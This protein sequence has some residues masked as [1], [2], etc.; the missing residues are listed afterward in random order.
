MTSERGIVQ[1]MCVGGVRRQC[2]GAAVPGV[3]Q[4]ARGLRQAAVW[5]QRAVLVLPVVGRG[6]VALSGLVVWMG[7]FICRPQMQGLRG[8]RRLVGGGAVLV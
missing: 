7:M 8:M 2:F 5:R 3:R 6:L 4:A 1:A